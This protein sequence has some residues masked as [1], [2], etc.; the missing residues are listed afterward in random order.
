LPRLG[1]DIAQ[2][3]VVG[4]PT[5]S[6]PVAELLARRDIELTVVAEGGDWIDP[7]WAVTTVATD[8]ELPLADPAWL[9]RWHAL[10]AV[11]ALPADVPGETVGTVMTGGAGLSPVV[12]GETVGAVP[13]TGVIAPP[14][15]SG[16]AVE[17]SLTGAAGLSPDTAGG[18]A[19]ASLTGAGGLSPDTAGAPLTGAALA[20]AVWAALG[21]GDNLMLGP[22]QIVRQAEQAPIR[23]DPPAVYANRGLAGIDGVIATALGL[24]AATDRPTTVL[25]GDLT[26]VHDLGSLVIPARERPIDLRLVIADDN[27]GSIFAG[28]EP[29]QARGPAAEA[30]E[31]C[32]TVPP[33]VDLAAGAVALGASAVQVATAAE[34]A[35]ALA[36]PWSGRHVNV[37]ALGG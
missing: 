9:D 25:L 15:A 14:V 23:P 29:G 33:G 11:A 21:P 24:A 37:A 20:A 30:L 3:V 4:H 27:G 18:A 6:R 32:F 1:A 7:G 31:R 22:S 2:V 36:Q 10:D 17:T 28:L 19:G 12:S 26:A 16:E 13:P 8:V 34:L 35:D 5:L